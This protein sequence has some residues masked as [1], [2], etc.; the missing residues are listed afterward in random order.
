MIA[1]AS[2]DK[3]VRLWNVTT[4][5]QLQIMQYDKGFVRE[6]TFLPNELVISVS[7]DELNWFWNLWNPMTLE[8][9]SYCITAAHQKTTSD[10]VFRGVNLDADEVWITKGSEKLVWLPPEYRP[11]DWA[12]RSSTIFIGCA[13]G[14]VIRFQA[15]QP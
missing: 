10:P 8:Y 9:H 11:T 6:I 4:G 2:R 15:S 13:S 3:M 7:N 12:N 5:I 1:S 14:R